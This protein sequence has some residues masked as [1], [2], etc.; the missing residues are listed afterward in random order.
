MFKETTSFLLKRHLDQGQSASGLFVTRHCHYRHVTHIHAQTSHSFLCSLTHKSVSLHPC[1]Q[2]VHMQT[3]KS[4]CRHKRCG[5]TQRLSHTLEHL[6]GMWRILWHTVYLTSKS[7]GRDESIW[8]REDISIWA[9]HM[10]HHRLCFMLLYR[11]LYLKYFPLKGGRC[12]LTL[13][14]VCSITLKTVSQNFFSTLHHCVS[15]PFHL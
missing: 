11:P 10:P 14:S 3:H 5:H 9:S 13:H 12:P 15:V 4:K 6:G 7:W 1:F 2:W 8:V